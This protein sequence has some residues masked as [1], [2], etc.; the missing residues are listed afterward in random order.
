LGWQA[1]KTIL[2]ALDLDTDRELTDKEHVD[3]SSA[4]IYL[5]FFY[6]SDTII[7]ANNAVRSLL[8]AAANRVL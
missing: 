2:R 3:S 8:Q 6:D 1:R 7:F 5:D 4:A